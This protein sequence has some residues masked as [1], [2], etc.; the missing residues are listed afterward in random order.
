MSK[1]IPATKIIHV[2]FCNIARTHGTTRISTRLFFLVAMVVC[3]KQFT[4]AIAWH[5]HRGRRCRHWHSGI[6][7][8]YPVRYRSIPV[9]NWSSYSG[10]AVPDWFWHWHLCSVWYRNDRMPDS[11]TFLN[12]KKD[13]P[14]MS[15]LLRWI[16]MDTLPHQL[17]CRRQR[18]TT[19]RK[20][21]RRLP[22]LSGER[23][24]KSKSAWRERTAA[25]R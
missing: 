21:R 12:L 15:A 10:T 4:I 6:L 11:P 1:K 23:V 7:Y 13:T 2:F 9:P 18:R 8:L 25:Q 24:C 20:R 19:G 5:R 22:P 16:G 17:R 3:S 14:C